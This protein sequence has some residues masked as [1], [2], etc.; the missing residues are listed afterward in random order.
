MK[1]NPKPEIKHSFI[2]RESE[3]L[4]REGGLKSQFLRA[5]DKKKCCIGIFLISCGILEEQLVGVK[6]PEI[7][8]K[9]GGVLPQQAKWLIEKDGTSGLA[10]Y[11]MTRNDMEFGLTE[12]K[13]KEAIKKGFAQGGVEAIFVP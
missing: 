8:I 2:I 6:T 13:Q 4:H 12:E 11:L 7:F 5:E 1:N 3:W 9:N 10:K